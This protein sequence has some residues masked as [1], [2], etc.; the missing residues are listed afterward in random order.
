MANPLC[1]ITE[2]KSSYFRNP[3]YYLDNLLF[4]DFYR[5]FLVNRSAELV[6]PLFWQVSCV[7]IVGYVLLLN[8]STVYSLHYAET[9]EYLIVECY[10]LL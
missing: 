2:E 8:G 9:V 5:H 3:F 4:T 6:V 1:D 10:L 7:K